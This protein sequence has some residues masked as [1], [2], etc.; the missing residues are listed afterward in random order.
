TSITNATVD[1]TIQSCVTVGT[2]P[3]LES[4]ADRF[5]GKLNCTANDVSL[6]NINV[7]GTT[8]CIFGQPVTLQLTGDFN[9]TANNRYDVGVYFSQDGLDLQKQSTAGG[10]ASA[11][12]ATLTTAMGLITNQDGD[13]CLD[14]NAGLTSGVTLPVVT[15]NCLPNPTTGRLD[16]VSLVSWSQQANNNCGGPQDVTVGEGNASSKCTNS[17]TATNVVV[18]GQ[19]NITKVV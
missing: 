3:A 8:Q 7:V 13:A 6:G 4:P 11:S 5:G 2:Y 12:V 1:P 14:A 17:T 16:L 10:A 9:V 15:L 19:I 18:L